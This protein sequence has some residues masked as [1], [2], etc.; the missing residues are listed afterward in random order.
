LRP[1]ILVNRVAARVAVVRPFPQFRVL[2]SYGV[3]VL[4]NPRVALEFVLF[5]RETSNFTY[6]IANRGELVAT[7]TS[8]L[9][10]PQESIQA[11]IR[12]VD[13]DLAFSRRVQENRRREY[14]RHSRVHFGRRI[15]WY[16]AARWLKPRTVIET[17]TADGLGTAIL[18]RALARNEADGY[19]GR[20]ISFDVEPRAGWLLDEELSRRT[21]VVIGDVRETLPREL[22]GR[23]VEL[24]VHDSLHT[25]E[26]E[27][28][29][30]E[31]IYAHSGA[32][33]VTAISDNAH[34]TTALAD[35]SAEL[36][37]EF[38]LFRE[39]PVEHFY[40]GAALGIATLPAR[41]H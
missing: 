38:V 10:A 4:R 1:E 24:F 9:N 41:G 26:H 20:L 33:G 15:G 30:L 12:E 27:R 39:Q 40:P 23:T 37:A 16:A 29:E 3:W 2:R 11:Y 31:V 21:Q 18:S 36:G 32:T 13:E 22:H 14:G 6:E 19:P 34:A 35:F 25:Y 28:F 8:A 17:G 5:D 7:L